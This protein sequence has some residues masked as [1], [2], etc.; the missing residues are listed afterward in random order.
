MKRI[1]IIS[2]IIAITLPS[3]VYADSGTTQLA[4]VGLLHLT[5][6]NFLIGIL[7]GL[8]I[9]SIFRVKKIRSI[10]LMIG[11]NYFSCILGY[12]ISIG[13]YYLIF[14]WSPGSLLYKTPQL[15]KTFWVLS[16]F[17]TLLLEWPFCFWVLAGSGNRMKKS[18]ARRFN[19][20]NRLLFNPCAPLYVR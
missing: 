18:I 7:E 9:S 20:P 19:C 17:V 3:L 5:I 10:L 14:L 13:I 2:I 12:L 16:Y 15:V 8:L 1:L 11:A 6:G 4:G